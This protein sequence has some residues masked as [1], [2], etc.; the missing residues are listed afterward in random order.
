MTRTSDTDYFVADTHALIWHLSSSSLLSTE[1]KRRFL[2]A[3]R[4]EAVIFISVLSLI[5]MIY[6]EEKGKIPAHFWK[7]FLQL[8]QAHEQGSYRLTPISTEVAISLAFV[9]REKIPELPDRIIA[10]T[11]YHLKHPLITKDHRIQDWE[12]IVTVW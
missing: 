11:A 3:D 12:G 5:E 8:L 7:S 9:P 4:G 2:Q 10:A 1:A 6:L